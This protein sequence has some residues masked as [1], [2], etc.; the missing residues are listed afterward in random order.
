MKIS[1]WEKWILV[2]TAAFLLLNVGYFL[3]QRSSEPYRVDVQ[4][5]WTEEVGAN[6]AEQNSTGK[7]LVNINTADVYQL[8]TLPGI[9]QIRAEEIIEEREQ[10]GEFR[11]PE[12]ILRVSGIGEGTLQGMIDCI[13]VN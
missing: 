5:L 7:E 2:F 13:T 3:G 9:G 11:I 4:T 12:D 6:A 8:Q 10:N 1:A